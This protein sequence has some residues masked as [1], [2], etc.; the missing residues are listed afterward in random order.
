MESLFSG[1]V[2]YILTLSK[3]IAILAITAGGLCHAIPVTYIKRFGE[4]FFWGGIIGFIIMN[5][6]P[7]ILNMVGV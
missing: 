4:Q 1:M 6:A 7:D 3:P 2:S 5:F